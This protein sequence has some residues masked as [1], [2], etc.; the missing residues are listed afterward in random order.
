MVLDRGAGGKASLDAAA[1]MLAEAE[2]PVI[3]SG[4]VW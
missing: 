3:V 2:F 4:V 1:D